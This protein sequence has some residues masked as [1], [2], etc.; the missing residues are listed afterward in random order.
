MEFLAGIDLHNLVAKD[1][2]LPE[3]RVRYILEQV[4]G[5]IAEAHE[6]GMVHRDIKPPNIMLCRRGGIADL[7]KVLDFGLVKDVR[8]DDGFTME[9]ALTGTPHYM[10][11]EAITETDRVDG[12]TD[13]YAVGAVGYF[14]LAGR[15][16]F[17]GPTAMAVLTK[18]ISNSPPHPSLD[19][20]YPVSAG[21][22]AFLM[23]CLEKDQVRR[24]ASAREA[25]R[26]LTRLPQEGEPWTQEVAQKWWDDHQEL[27]AQPQSVVDS[28]V[29]TVE[30]DVSARDSPM[31]PSEAG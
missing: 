15:Q 31:G 13:L 10:A 6:H 18:Q 28:I 5:S 9:N 20:R 27:H 1:G 3:H 14:L 29:P 23:N 2:P 11:P 17:N 8:A 25:L 12:R 4:L 7:V 30:I 22:E 21:F 26:T 16:L 19:S 24:P